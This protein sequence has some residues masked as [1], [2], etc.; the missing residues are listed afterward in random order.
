MVKLLHRVYFDTDGFKQSMSE[1]VLVDKEL[2]LCFQKKEWSLDKYIRE[3]ITREETCEEIRSTPGK[4][5]ESAQLAV[6][7]D[8]RNYGKL[9]ES[10][11]V[12]DIEARKGYIRAEEKKYLAVLYFKGLNNVHFPKLKQ[13]VHNNWIVHR[14]NTTP[15]TIKQT[16]QMCN[17]FRQKG[18]QYNVPIKNKDG[19]ACLQ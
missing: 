13:E 14:I 6:S 1:M 16:L 7:T 10:D 4:C 11:N 15:K 12:Y 17:K 3:L 18:H 19:V 8:G 2:F 5:L 9:A